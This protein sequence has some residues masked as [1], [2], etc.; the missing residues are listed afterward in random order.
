MSIYFVYRSH[1]DNAT[2]KHLKRFDDPSI[3]DWFR[4]RW[5]RWADS[6][7]I[8]HSVAEELGRD[9]YSFGRLFQT[10]A[11][12]NLDPPATYEELGQ[13]IEENMYTLELIRESEHVIEFFTDDDELEMAWYFFDDE[14]VRQQPGL[15]SFLLHEDWKLP[16]TFQDGDF[17]P[18][19]DDSTEPI[20][21]AGDG[22]G[23]TYIALLAYSDSGNLSDI[24]GAHT[25]E[26][27]RVPDLARHLAQST[28]TDNWPFELTAVRSQLF[29]DFDGL[30]EDE[31]PFVT[32]I[33]QNPIDVE[34][35]SVYSDWLEERGLGD[36]PTQFLEQALRQ[37]TN[38][39]DLQLDPHG[40]FRPRIARR[41]G[42]RVRGIFTTGRP[43][44]H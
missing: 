33:R 19:D 40:R 8:Y 11:E 10:V 9:V 1:Y 32:A 22:D 26:G 4:N 28:P 16:T 3:L 24:E 35:W 44:R 27:I 38:H 17:S 30:H 43:R 20:E 31:R 6:E 25:I 12:Q 15:T 2:Q 14:F 37:M 36:R 42:P 39:P 23:T 7:D 5:T 41:G 21:P 29:K 13:R 18:S 34:T